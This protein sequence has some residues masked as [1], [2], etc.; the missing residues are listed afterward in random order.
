MRELI[1]MILL[2]YF[3]LLCGL[4]CC[5]SEQE[6]REK[7]CREE[8]LKQLRE[9]ETTFYSTNNLDQSKQSAIL[10]WAQNNEELQKTVVECVKSVRPIVHDDI[11][12][13]CFQFVGGKKSDKGDLWN[14]YGSR[15]VDS[16]MLGF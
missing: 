16:L 5:A 13:L 10:A 15:R 6:G 3:M 14:N 7:R 11:F 12:T 4:S 2:L 8:Q 1:M 9:N